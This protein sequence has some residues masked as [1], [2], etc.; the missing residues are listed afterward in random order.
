MLTAQAP[1]RDETGPV[2]TLQMKGQRRRHS[3]TALSNLVDLRLAKSADEVRQRDKA[4][5]FEV[6]L[7]VASGSR[8]SPAQEGADRTDIRAVMLR[9]R[10]DNVLM[11]DE[12]VAVVA[13]RIDETDALVGR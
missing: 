9:I 4:D 7:V 1:P 5:R 10:R 6:F 11:V 3:L 13:G 8:D 2:K 12:S